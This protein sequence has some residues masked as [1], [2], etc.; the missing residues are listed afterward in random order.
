[1]DGEKA[2]K[3]TQAWGWLAAGVMALGLN[4]IYHDGGSEWA[5]RMFAPAID[6][7]EAQAGPLLALAEG[8]TDRFLAMTRVTIARNETASCRVGTA[9]ARVQNKMARASR[10]NRFQTMTARQ[11]AAVAL[12]EAD[13]A[14]IE[15]QMAKMQVRAFP[16][17]FVKVG[18]SCPR[19]EVSAPEISIPQVP[20]VSASMVEVEMPGKEPI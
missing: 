5:R 6:R 13:R 12:M 16:A 10:S 8:R 15:A 3:T 1:M 17:T 11:E 2:M 9:V 4:G 18:S 19:V 20:V 14:K 7:I